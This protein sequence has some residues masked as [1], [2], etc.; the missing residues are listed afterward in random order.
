MEALQLEDERDYFRELLDVLFVALIKFLPK[1][2]KE[3]STA[4]NNL[5]TIV[6]KKKKDGYMFLGGKMMKVV[7]E[8]DDRE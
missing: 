3:Q 1:L 6:G 4:A 2:S 7:G 8:I 5:K